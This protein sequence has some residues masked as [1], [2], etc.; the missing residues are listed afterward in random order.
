MGFDLCLRSLV[1]S[2]FGGDGSGVGGPNG[3][4]EFQCVSRSAGKCGKA[5]VMPV[6]PGFPL[7]RKSMFVTPRSL[8]AM[9]RTS[10]P[11]LG[12]LLALRREGY[13][14]WKRGYAASKLLPRKNPTPTL[15]AAKRPSWS[16]CRIELSSRCLRFPKRF[17]A[18]VPLPWNRGRY[19]R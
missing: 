15:R 4:S 18:S 10:D 9:G 7:Q 19:Q 2:R 14:S 17:T 6:L 5:G 8:L 16:R 12:N 1:V 3:G 11:P 13:R